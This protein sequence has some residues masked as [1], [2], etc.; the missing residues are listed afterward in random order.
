M[1]LILCGLIALNLINTVCCV[2]M[3]VLTIKENK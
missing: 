2:T 1:I 3:L